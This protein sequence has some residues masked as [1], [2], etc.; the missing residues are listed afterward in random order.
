MK[1]CTECKHHQ[2]LHGADRCLRGVVRRFEPIRGYEKFSSGE[3]CENRRNRG[4][5]ALLKLT[6]GPSGIFW[7]PKR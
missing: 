4:L 3:F 1:I 2:E 6:C 5:R 7:E